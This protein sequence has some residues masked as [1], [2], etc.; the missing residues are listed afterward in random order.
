MSKINTQPL[1]EIIEYFENLDPWKLNQLGAAF[2]LGHNCGCCVGAHLAHI[3]GIAQGL[4]NDFTKGSKELAERMGYEK[5]MASPAV[6]Y[7]EIDLSKFG[8]PRAA[9]GAQEWEI[10]PE[11]VFQKM[12]EHYDGA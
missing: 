12:M 6:F 9:F 10:P 1:P 4:S 11:Q 2:Q 8:A 7:L 5:T 3:F